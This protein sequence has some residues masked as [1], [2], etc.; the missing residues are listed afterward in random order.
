MLTDF[1]RG[2][3]D[4]LCQRILARERL[5]LHAERMPLTGQFRHLRRRHGLDP[6]LHKL[7]IV[8]KIDLRH[9][10]GGRKA[11]L[12]F[13]AVAAHRSDVVERALLAAHDPLS[14]RHIRIGRIGGFGLKR[15]FIESGWQHIDQIDVA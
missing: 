10:G 14:G 12:I 3:L 8:G 9:A 13:E 11:P 5:I 1:F 6:G 2:R 15:R 4:R 7:A